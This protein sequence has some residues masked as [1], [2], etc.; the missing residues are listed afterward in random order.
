[1][2]KYYFDKKEE[3]ENYK[4]LNVFLLKK[5]GFFKDDF[6]TGIVTWSISGTKTGS[7]SV[8]SYL[9][10]G[11][12]VIR[13]IYTITN[14]QSGEAV[15]Y[16]YVASLTKTV[17]YFGGYRYWFVCPMFA[18][19]LYC[20]R[21]VASLYLGDNY[22]AC[23]HCHN[24]TYSSRNEG[25]I[26]KILGQAVSF[27]ELDKLRRSIKRTHYAGKPTRKHR[28]YFKKLAKSEWQLSIIATGLKA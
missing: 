24:L 28:S 25:G 22:F 21:R 26:S 27:P 3:V 20:R 5:H 19:G 18:N 2:S 1:M 8:Q 15:D 6:N 9:E 7:V 10:E 23:R 4:Q 13:L 17:C 12:R 11:K 16:N 14:R